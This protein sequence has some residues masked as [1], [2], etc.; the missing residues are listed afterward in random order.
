MI[1]NDII[2]IAEASKIN[3]RRKGF[4]K[5]ILNEDEQYSILNSDNPGLTLW[6]LW[7][8]KESA[9]KIFLR[10]NF[11][12]IYNPLKFECRLIIKK[13]D[14]IFRRGFF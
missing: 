10:K 5:K 3:W 1:G 7:S 8:M 13:S 11:I 12:R 6:L 4:L 2:D 14:L 9:Y